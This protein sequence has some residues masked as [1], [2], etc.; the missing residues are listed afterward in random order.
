MSQTQGLPPNP[1]QSF[2]TLALALMAALVMIGVATWFVL[3]VE[4]GVFRPPWWLLGGQLAAEVVV[5][6]LLD[7]VGY[8]AKPLDPGL[9]AAEAARLSYAGWQQAAILRFMLS[10]SIALVSLA[11]AFAL[12]EVGWLGYVTGA[13]VALVLMLWHVYPWQR[14]VQR[15]VASLERAGGASPLHTLL[16]LPEPLR[17]PIRE[18]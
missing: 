6:L 15:T 2:R 18:L 13:V 7:A 8:R 12:P 9:P 4:D 1:A 11:L 14:P 5:H 17:G 3:G 16:G 10:E